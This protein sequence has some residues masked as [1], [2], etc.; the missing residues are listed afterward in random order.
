MNA[1]ITTP[2][3]FRRMSPPSTW[4]LGDPTAIHEI[5]YM[6]ATIWSNRPAVKKKDAAKPG[7]S[8]T[9]PQ[10]WIDRKGVHN[11]SN[12]DDGDPVDAHRAA[13]AAIGEFG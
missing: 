11:A 7:S 10:N 5:G 9:I 13:R 6:G 8:G 3:L 4:Q 2:S 1:A 12:R